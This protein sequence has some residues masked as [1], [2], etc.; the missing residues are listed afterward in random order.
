M[1][2]PFMR[3]PE[4]A[5]RVP[6]TFAPDVSESATPV[7]PASAGYVR[8]MRDAAPGELQQTGAALQDAGAFASRLGN[9]IGDRVQSTMDDAATKAAENQFLQNSLPA[10]SQYSSTEGINATQQFEPTAQAI[11]KARQE[12]RDTLTNPI[13][14]QMFDQVTNNHMLTFGAQM[15][16]HENTQ[17]VQ[18]GKDQA[19][20]RAANLNQLS[21]LDVAGRDRPGSNFSNYGLASDAEVLHYAQLAGMAPDSPQAQEL[22]RQNRTQRY[23]SVVT[24]LL[25]QHAYN[26]AGDF[27][28]EH[29]DEMDVRAAAVLGN[30]VK[31]ATDSEQVTQYRN[32]A[33][34]SLKKTPG[35]GPLQQPIPAGTISTT[36]GENGLDIFTAPGTNVHAPA[37]GT[38]SKVW[39]DPQL[40]LSAQVT[41]PN[42]YV[43]TFNGLSAVNYKQ[44]QKITAGQVLGLTGKNAKGNGVMHYAMTDPSGTYIDPRQ[45]VSAPYD[46]RNF[47]TPE[48][49]A[50]AVDWVEQHV[51]DPVMQSEVISRV[52]SLA[53]MNRQIDNQQH[54]D[55]V[56]QA[57]DYSLSHGGS[58]DGLPAQVRM[59]LT[60]EDMQGFEAKGLQQYHLGQTEKERDEV[61]LLAQ[62]DANPQTMTVD[63]V[64][65][66][67]AQGKLSDAT[68][69]TSLRQA[70][71]LQGGTTGTTDPGKVQNAT[72]DHSQ[73][74]DILRLNNLPNLAQ[75]KTPQDQYGRASL[76]TAIRNEIQRQQ[77]NLKRPL[78]WQEKG[79][80]ARD[81]VIDKVYTSTGILGGGEGLMP[82][83]AATPQ[84]QQNAVVF[85]H[86]T[87]VRMSEVP[88]KY[89][90]EATEDL[91]NNRLPAT[92]ANIAAWWLHK[93]SP[94]Q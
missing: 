20:A 14:Q 73:L 44:G 83:T 84:E 82:F 65:T 8:P 25:D 64:R 89:A 22:L 67:Y 26:E 27:F 88:P 51:T 69:L 90:L 60:P 11:A 49:E 79:K 54:A 55:A 34:Q 80:I 15:A 93:G 45:A 48:D 62:W 5:G 91:E 28:N 29:K 76:E 50:Q 75:P 85:V 18:Y 53:N 72:M 68:Y 74:N 35:A 40:G 92:Q 61:P 21:T 1:I 57:T 31:T 66:A 30:A 32:L 77:D 63:A 46:P 41:L 43:A 39:Q 6:G 78:T 37:N 52:R 33:V 9:T 70:E 17:R 94:T 58:L 23:Q 12:A 7:S 10:L 3:A 13:Q 87:K 2:N 71:H 86:G 19:K 38:V 42:G 56:K 81:M 4:F 16:A 47:S 24:S 59:Q 36:A